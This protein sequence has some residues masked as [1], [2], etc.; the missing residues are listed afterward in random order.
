MSKKKKKREKRA[1]RTTSAAAKRR[2]ETHKTG[3]D[4]T[5]FEMPD[6]TKQFALKS[7][8]AVRL[9]IIP[10]EVGEGNPYADPG[11]LHYERTYF[12]HRAIGVDQTSFICLKK[13]N[14]EDCPIC[15]FRAKLMKDPDADEALIK[16]LAPKERQLF[17]V[18][19]TKDKDKGVQ[20]WDISFHL[21]G[22]RLDTEIKNS[23]EDD[24]YENFAELEGGFTLKCSVEE[25]SF[26]QTFYE[27]SSINFKPRNDD[28]D[29]D[30]LEET[31]CLDDI[32]IIK[33]YDELKEIFLQTVDEDEDDPDDKKSKKSKKSKQAEKEKEENEEKEDDPN[34]PE[35]EEDDRVIIK[36]DGV[37]YHGKIGSID[38]DDE[39]VTVECDD[40]DEVEDIAFDDLEAEPEKEKKSKKSKKKDKDEKKGKKERKKEKEKCPGGGTFGRNTD[41]LPDCTDCSKWNECDDA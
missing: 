7:D 24:G 26:G 5:A 16:G 32:L 22:K 18:I 33:E 20:V 21:F 3:F 34:D 19:N 30:I 39:T 8:R 2:A 40:G 28:Y 27:V 23:D 38:E 1:S 12:V 25:K 4:N 14:S 36:V 29:E 31:T 17:N 10:Y 41:E 9:D 11:E 13:T 35:W 37:K 6:D 15:E